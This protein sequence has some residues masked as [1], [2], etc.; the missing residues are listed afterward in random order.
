MLL[1]SGILAFFNTC[2]ERRTIRIDGSS[3]VYR[4]TEAVVEEFL[5]ENEGIHPDV[6]VSGSGGGFQKFCDGSLDISNASRAITEAEI[7]KCDDS[8]IE[9]IELPV[10]YDGLTVVVHRDNEF[11]EEFTIEDLKKIFSAKNPASSWKEVNDRYPD[12]PVKAASPGQDSGTFDYFADIVMHESGQLRP[13]ALVSEDDNTIVRA[14]SGDKYAVGFF[15]FAYYVESKE[16]LRP[17]PIVNPKTGKAVVPSPETIKNG[18][19]SPLS[20]PLFI[21]VNKEALNNPDVDKFVEFYLEKAGSL[22]K[23][24]GYIPLS[25][26]AYRKIKDHYS[27]RVTG[28]RF[29]DKEL[30]GK[31][32]ESLY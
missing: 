25:Q 4:I 3:T 28:S 5:N 7:Q 8:G 17:V 21:Y 12:L 23:D 2:Q 32:V 31:S 20:R 1:A 15:G 26:E 29:A 18:S 13:D 24:V 22:S 11:V 16:A 19:Y 14:V 10:A 27:N 6:G 9:F 30:Q